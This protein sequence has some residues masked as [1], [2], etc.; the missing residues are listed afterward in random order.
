MRA[1]AVTFDAAT[2]KLL[3]TMPAPQP[4]RSTESVSTIPAS[5]SASVANH[6]F[7]TFWISVPAAKLVPAAS[8]TAVSVA[9]GTDAAAVNPNSCMAQYHACGGNKKGFRVRVWEDR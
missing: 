5:I 7:V 9:F 2:S 6:C 8:I 3:K 1:R 4:C